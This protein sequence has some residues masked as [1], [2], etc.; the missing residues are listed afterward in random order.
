MF[1]F[2]H[3]SVESRNTSSSLCCDDSRLPVRKR[4]VLA[5]HSHESP[6]ENWTETD[7]LICV[8]WPHAVGSA[9]FLCRAPDHD[10]VGFLLRSHPTNHQRSRWLKWN[11]VT[12]KNHDISCD[13]GTYVMVSF[14]S[15]LDYTFETHGT[16]NT[17][18]WRCKRLNVL[19]HRKEQTPGVYLCLFKSD[20]CH[21]C[22]SALV[23]L[24]IDF[25]FLFATF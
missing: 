21:C 24:E 7:S 25:F 3:W 10:S 5:S 19:A 6:G 12:F 8:K 22:I 15:P 23:S 9:G 18:H 1:F 4:Q 16:L 2:N 13:S 20:L 17:F 11:R 14:I